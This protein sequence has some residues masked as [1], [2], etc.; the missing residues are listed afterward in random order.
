[1]GTLKGK[2]QAVLKSTK[3]GEIAIVGY[4]CRL[5]GAPDAEAFW[6]LLRGE[7]HRLAFALAT[8][9]VATVLGLAVPYSSKIVIDYVLTDNPGPSGLPSFVNGALGIDPADD[10]TRRTLLFALGGSILVVSLL[11][12]SIALSGRWQCTKLTK[13]TQAMLRKKAFAHAVRLPLSRISE[14]KSGGVA[15]ILREDAGNAG[16]GGHALAQRA[17]DA[18]CGR[19]ARRG[20]GRSLRLPPAAIPACRIAAG[21]PPAPSLAAY[22]S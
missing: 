3:P 1:M 16:R 22:E 10:G 20:P 12:A 18:S 9:T 2:G 15:S 8:L 6:D 7:R 17:A 4:G 14:L 19:C 13:R 21:R 5:P 11:A